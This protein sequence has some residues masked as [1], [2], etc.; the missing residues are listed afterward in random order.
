MMSKSVMLIGFLFLMQYTSEII[1]FKSS[2][3]VKIW[4]NKGLNVL[5]QKTGK[6]SM[7]LT[8]DSLKEA[9]QLSPSKISQ[10]L[11]TQYELSPQQFIY[12]VLTSV[13]VTCLI[14]A[15][16]VG[17]KLFEIPLPFEIFGH[18]TVEH[19]CGMLTFPITFLLG[20]IINEYYGPKAAKNS[21]YIGL[22][23]SMLVFLVMNIAQ[24]MPYLDKP[25]NV[26]QSS[27]D[28]IFGSAKLMYVASVSAYLVGSL[29]DIWLFGVIKKATKGKLLWL[30]ATG[31]TVISQILDSFFVSYIAF[32]LGKS[33]TGQTP[34]T[35][36][37]VLDIAATGYTLKFVLAAA[38]TPFLYILKSILTEQF[39]LQPIPA[40]TDVVN[41]PELAIVS[42]VEDNDKR[43]V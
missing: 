25:F 22:A 13:F 24:A 27:F 39:G 11:S 41:M 35:I 17:V 33:L 18:K 43:N 14:V 38:M 34:A 29:S 36:P 20:D 19:T 26:T 42:D 8:T 7:A 32:S 6:I 3:A 1:A 15:D 21:V 2:L 37:E 9:K 40:D 31:S 12:V 5:T 4:T 23:M 30:R 16:V 28:M 10:D